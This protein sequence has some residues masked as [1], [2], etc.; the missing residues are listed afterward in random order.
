[1]NEGPVI[2]AKPQPTDTLLAIRE[3]VERYEAYTGD[4][5]LQEM[6]SLITDV[7]SENYNGAT[8]NQTKLQ[9][10]TSG[11]TAQV[12]LIYTENG[13]DFSGKSLWLTLENGALIQMTDG[14]FLFNVGSTQVNILEQQAIQIAVNQ[15]KDFTWNTN[16]TQVTNFNVVEE[17]IIA[18]FIP[19]PRT[20]SLALIPY[21]YITLPLDKVYPGEVSRIA[22]GVWADN[23][24]IASIQ[25]LSS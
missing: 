2:Y 20:K 11:S 9:V 12:L 4:A 24:E 7:N 25:T 5:Y 1:V 22:V 19:H 16:G 3:L 15:L 10:T 13:I 18:Q 8:L 23:G 6:L 14:W 17:K 21:W